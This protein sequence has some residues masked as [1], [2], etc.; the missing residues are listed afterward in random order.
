MSQLSGRMV[1]LGQ[2]GQLFLVR[3]LLRFFAPAAH[4]LVLNRIAF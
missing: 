3:K 4:T 2:L 1:G